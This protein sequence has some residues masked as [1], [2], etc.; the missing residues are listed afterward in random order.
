MFGFRHGK[1]V[2]L[3]KE[4]V[5]TRLKLRGS[6]DVNNRLYIK[7]LGS[8]QTFSLPEGTIV[9]LLEAAIVGQ[10]KGVMLHHVL[11]RQETQRSLVSGSDN[12]TFQEII[13]IC[14]ESNPAEA[15]L[16]YCS[17]RINIENK[18]NFEKII[19]EDEL[20]TLIPIAYDQIIK[21]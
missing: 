21:W 17:Y 16:K 15:M 8:F 4:L 14:L 18:N 12:H 19:T 11:Q 2:A 13:K 5:E 3:I 9:A 6:D 10:S 7:S 20:M 1:R